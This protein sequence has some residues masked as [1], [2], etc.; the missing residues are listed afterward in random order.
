MAIYDKFTDRS[1]KKLA[2]LIDPDKPTDAQIISI[3]E[4]AKAADVDFFFV[5]GSL[6]VTDSLDHC[7]KLIKANC[8]HSDFREAD[9]QRW[10][11]DRDRPGHHPLFHAYP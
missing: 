7:I 11:G 2:V 9:P 1:R 5:G 4:K 8:S 3:V 10:S 6:L